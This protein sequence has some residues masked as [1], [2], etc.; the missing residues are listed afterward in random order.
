[1]APDPAPLVVLPALIGKPPR[2]SY[3][4][5]ME[6]AV[7]AENPLKPGHIVGLGIP[8]RLLDRDQA[9]DWA[10]AMMTSFQFLGAFIAGDAPGQK[11]WLFVYTHRRLR[12]AVISAASIEE[13]CTFM[14][15]LAESGELICSNMH[16]S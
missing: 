10:F 15:T 13:A 11:D 14:D 3:A 8:S 4:L 7:I 1:M 5:V 16:T 12:L 6:F 2:R 9:T